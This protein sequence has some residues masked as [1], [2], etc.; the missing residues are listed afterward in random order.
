MGRRLMV[1]L[2]ALWF[3]FGVGTAF[4]WWIASRHATMC[5]TQIVDFDIDGL[6]N[7][8]VAA[9]PAAATGPGTVTFALDL[10]GIHVH[11]D[12]A[13]V[14]QTYDAKVAALVRGSPVTLELRRDLLRRLLSR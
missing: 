1:R 5:R 11:A 14:D 6:T 7:A 4:G 13:F 12:S 9:L 2:L 3:A 8:A 10:T